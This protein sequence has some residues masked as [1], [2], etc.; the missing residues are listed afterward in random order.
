MIAVTGATGALGQ[1]VIGKLLEKVD[2]KQVLGLV[3]DP[4]NTGPLASLGIQLRQADYNQP[5]TLVD[6]FKGVTRLLL[7]SS[8]AIGSRVAQHKA[9]IDAAK[10]TG[11]EVLVYTS[12][13]KAD[14]NP[15]ILAQE[16]QPTEDYINASGL[17]AVILR[18]GWYTENYTQS[19]D[20]ILQAGAVFGAAKDGEFYTAPRG[21]YAEAAARVLLEPDEHLGQTYELAGDTSFTLTEFAAEISKLTSRDIAYNNMTMQDL[22]KHLEEVGLPAGFAAAL[23]D[24][25]HYAAEGYLVD[26]SGALSGLLGRAT[27]PWQNTLKTQ[28]TQ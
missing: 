5:Q 8:N 18:N 6:A 21:D 13:L 12:V 28:L 14:N 23:A 27:M 19:L 3:R 22:Q 15:M 17:P 7:I 2:A 16:H 25:E 20:G 24:S 11:V 26:K 10:Q 4:Q 1:L 9:V